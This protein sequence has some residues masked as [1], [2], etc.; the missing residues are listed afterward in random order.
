MIRD[1][2]DLK[3]SG[4]IVIKAGTSIVSTPDGF[5]SLIRMANIVE[6]AAQLA[7]EGK[8]VMIVTS[9]AV[10]VGRQRLKKQAM[11]K[12]SMSDI[13]TQ[14]SPD[15][16]RVNSGNLQNIPSAQSKVSYSSA[17]AAAGQMGLMSLY[18]MMFNQYD[19]ATSQLLVTAFDFT[20]PER[21]E[22]V[23]HVITQLLSLG[24]V[25][26]INEND[27]VSANQGYQTFGNSFSDND[28]LAAMVAIEMNAQVLIILTDEITSDKM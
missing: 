6:H 2:K 15:M 16:R 19:V 28:S 20:S 12:Q 23:Q 9:G 14:K 25:P 3:N 5:P 7:R 11:L 21:R 27:A 10:G 13:I 8:E 22:N 4:R 1:R 18:E 24:I 17:C 26:I